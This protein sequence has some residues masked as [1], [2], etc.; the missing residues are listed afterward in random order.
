MTSLNILYEPFFP[1]I[2]WGTETVGKKKILGP[3]SYVNV[4]WECFTI[5]PWPN[6]WDKVFKSGRSKFSGTQP[7][8]N[9]LCPLLNTLY[10][11]IYLQ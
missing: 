4:K 8:K 3:S 7:L 2:K 5:T 10:H 11:L 9:L 1:K 6:I